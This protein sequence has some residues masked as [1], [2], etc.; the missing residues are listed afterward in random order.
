MAWPLS[1]HPASR[2][3][4]LGAD[5]ELFI[6]TIGWDAHAL[7]TRPL[8]IFDANIFAPL[9]HTLAYSEHLIGSAIFAAPV[10]WLT[11]NPVLALNLTSLLTVVLCG[12]GTYVLARRVGVGTAGAILAGVIFAFSPPRFYRL[13]QLHLTA[14]QWVP[15][16]LAF[17]HGYFETRRRR[18]LWLAAGCF[19]LQALSSGH[20]TIFLGVAAAA[21]VAW[22]TARGQRIAPVRMLRDLGVPG[23]LLLLPVVLV[24][25]PYRLAQAEVGLR[26]SLVDWAVNA[27]SFLASPSHAQQSLL[28]LLDAGRVN[29][30]AGA[31]LFVGVLPLLLAIVALLPARPARSGR[32][33]SL[34][35]GALSVAAL[36]A[37]GVAAWVTWIEPIRLR[38]GS[39]VF[40]S[41]R[42]S[43][44]PWVVGG[45]LLAARLVL[46]RWLPFGAWASLPAWRARMA[47][48]RAERPD[49]ATGFY[50]ALTVLSV[51]L[52]IGP[53]L[54]I[55]PL[56]HWMPGLNFIRVPSR[57]MILALL[58]I[59]ILAGLGLERL[60]RGLSARTATA[61]AVAAIAGVTAELAVA[62]LDT[63]PYHLQIPA[64]DAWLAR[65]AGPFTIAE[66]PP[67]GLRGGLP[68]ARQQ[69]TYMLHSM[70][71]WQKTIHGH[72]GIEPAGHTKLY[73]RLLDFPSD[74]S[75]A[76][77][78]GAGVHYVVMHPALYPPGEWALVDARLA[79][80]TARL[81]LVHE[82]GQDR[83][84]SLK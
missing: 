61:L 35:A 20:G 21:L 6:W 69:S 62:P 65:Q 13:G 8:S 25:V 68:A 72:S 3:L 5:T 7:V 45:A 4:W 46:A 12:L 55:W 29:E 30:T 80:F 1:R 11:G 76:A 59:A 48:W 14:V 75:L 71:H 60:R 83:V 27:Q 31:Y 52:S 22:R 33:A 41:A 16:A 42:A 54:G 58:G 19:T 39:I 18:E 51:L 56:V 15:F 79:Q 28:S 67:A 40:F 24:A 26:R 32:L 36:G 17:L 74:D 66:F 57:F 84:Y 73:A 82:D 49:N 53:P 64:A 9:P 2:V 47:T 70:A 77:L 44:R 43:L 81:K 34:G 63:T 38:A 10:L 78:A 37:L 23:A 50:A